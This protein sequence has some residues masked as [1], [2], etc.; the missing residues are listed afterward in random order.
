MKD[1]TIFELDVEELEKSV[2]ETEKALERAGEMIFKAARGEMVKIV[3]DLLGRA[4]RR[5]P[6]REGYLRGSGLAKID[7]AK[8]AHTEKAGE[9]ARVVKDYLQG[10]TGL[11]KFID[12]LVGEVVFNTEY[13]TYQHEELELKHP[14]GG[15]AKYLQKPLYENADNYV[16]GIARAIKRELDGGGGFT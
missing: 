13:A 7:K 6:V 2:K 10:R 5:A 1:K 11:E 4:M 15:E 16:Q 12:E 9:T 14:K 8:V 3:F